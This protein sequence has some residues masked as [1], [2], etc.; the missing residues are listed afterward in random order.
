MNT[1]LLICIIVL[2][3]SIVVAVVFLVRTLIQVR[4]TAREAEVLLNSVNYE[5]NKV[6]TFSDNVMGFVETLMNSP[7]LRVGT[8][9][10]TIVGGIFTALK[11]KKTGSEK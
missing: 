9:A 2:T 3:A 5:A 6:K 11:K 4:K 8:A 10:S 1:V 7:W